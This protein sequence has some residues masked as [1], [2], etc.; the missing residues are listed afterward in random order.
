M[1]KN[2]IA[3]DIAKLLK[4]IASP[5]RLLIL[6]NLLEKE[7]NVSELLQNIKVSQS[8]LSQHLILLKQYDII[9]SHKVG[10][11]VYYSVI[12]QKTKDILGFLSKICST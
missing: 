5:V 6:C 11:F 8:A 7:K 12:N 4:Y 9:T 3:E 1:D 2:I 10:K